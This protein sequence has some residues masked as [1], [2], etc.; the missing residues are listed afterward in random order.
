MNFNT[1]T[2]FNQIQN[3][4][5]NINSYFPPSNQANPLPTNSYYSNETPSN[6]FLADYS[7]LKS[8]SRHYT[9]DHEKSVSSEVIDR[10][11]R[12]N[13]DEYSN[14][15]WNNKNKGKILLNFRKTNKSENYDRIINKRNLRKNLKAN[16]TKNKNKI[17]FS[18]NDSI[19]NDENES[20]EEDDKKAEN[21][22]NQPIK[23]LKKNSSEKSDD[24]I[25]MEELEM[26]KEFEKN[27]IDKEKPQ[28]NVN[29]NKDKKLKDNEEKADSGELEI[30]REELRNFNKNLTDKSSNNKLKKNIKRSEK[31]IEIKDNTK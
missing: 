31:N 23:N 9:F 24:K 12:S 18:E 26:I 5:S 8:P 14:G 28:I 7:V 16:F 15:D 29:K 21:K 6:V 1:L 17:N 10:N 25:K 11:E 2:N 30:I 20:E 19:L 22:G 27:D 3:G 13:E 4:F